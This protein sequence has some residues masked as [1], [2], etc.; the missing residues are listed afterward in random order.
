MTPHAASEA[1]FFLESSTF[2]IK[3]NWHFMTAVLLL[4]RERPGVTQHSFESRMLRRG[5]TCVVKVRCRVSRQV[6]LSKQYSQV[7]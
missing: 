1:T 2:T 7:L 6:S 5:T 3:D 4:K